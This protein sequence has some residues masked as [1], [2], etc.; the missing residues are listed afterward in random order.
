MKLTKIGQGLLAAAA[1]LGLG[2][3][4]TSCSPS[5]TID[6]LFVTSNNATAGSNGNGQVTAYHVDSASGALS[7]I[8]GPAVDSK[9]INPVAAVASP[10]QQYLYVANHGSN[11]IVEFAVGTDGQLSP[12][13]TYTTAG[14]EPVSLA[15]N[16]TGTLLFVLDYYGPGFSDTTPGPGILIVYPI[17]ADGSL[18]SPVASGGLPYSNLQCFPGGVA[19]SANGAYAYVT[20]TNTV[21]V[22]TSP[23]STATPPA[24]PSTCPSQGTISGFTV[25]ASGALTPIAGSPF[26]AGTTPTGIAIDLTSRF[27]YATDSVQNQLIVYQILGGGAL[28]PLPNG[29]FST[30]GTFPV[31][32]V[33]D[34]RDQYLYITNFNSS[35]ISAYTISQSTGQPS[36]LATSSFDTHGAAPTC[37]IVDP[38]FGRFLYTSL[39]HDSYV[40]AARLD[41]KTGELSGV[42]NSPYKVSGGATCV[43][44]VPHGNHASQ[45]VTAFPGQ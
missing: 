33:I 28:V 24:T 1:S 3:G 5:Q 23:P 22:T 11:N 30:N 31:G 38:A 7:Q 25:A 35:T 27:V 40:A 6:Y 32:I 26:P 45:Y 15:I 14:S 37:I 8:A 36:G 4:I 9:G 2:F 16:N 39:S 20:N 41:P 12:A 19:V 44:A 21:V 10:N 43:A 29:P 34:P 17:N 13:K 18:G 42:Q